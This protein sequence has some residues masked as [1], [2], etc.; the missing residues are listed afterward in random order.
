MTFQILVVTLLVGLTAMVGITVGLLLWLV[1][2]IQHTL[3][4]WLEVSRQIG[5]TRHLY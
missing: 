2:W 3:I 4:P 5:A 1:I